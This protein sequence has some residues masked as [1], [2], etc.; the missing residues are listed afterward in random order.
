MSK[1]NKVVLAYSGGLD[2]SVILKWLQDEYNCEVVTFTADLGQG[3]EVEPARAKAQALGVK[4]IYIDDL[5]EEFAR[6][7]IFP[8][9]RANTIYEGEYLLGTSIARPLIAKRLIEIA[10]ETNADAISHGATGKGNDQVR[11][12]LGAYALKPD[13]KVIAPWREWDLMSREKL[14]DYAEKNNIQIDRGG[15]KSPYS[16][17]ANLLHISYEGLA[18]ENPWNE[19]EVDMWRWTVSPEE[20]PNEPTYIELTFEKGDVVAIDGVEKSPATVMAEL[21]KIAGANGIGRVDIVENRYV[22]M[23]ARGCYETPAGT[24]ILKAHR[25]IESITL[26]REAAHLKDELMPRYASLIYNGYWWSPEREMLQA[27]IDKSQ[28]HVSGVVRLKLYKG[29]VIVVGRKSEASLFDENIA[30]FEDDAG[31]Y[32]QKDAAGFIKL[33]ALRLRTAAKRAHKNK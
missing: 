26:D 24:V 6:D 14:L 13:V 12:E 16:M 23:K 7:F 32:D 5:R 11:F 9:F 18:L 27:A 33:N 29:N 21:N 22:G 10:N 1:V 2:T 3:E 19:P 8:M 20:A 15:K 28:E 25:A 17:D 31:A 4:E 30:T